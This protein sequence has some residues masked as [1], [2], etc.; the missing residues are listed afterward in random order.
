MERI[1]E[2]RKRFQVL[3]LVEALG[4]ARGE[5]AERVASHDEEAA[6]LKQKLESAKDAL[7]RLEVDQNAYVSALGK[8]TEEIDRL[9]RELVQVTRE[10]DEARSLLEQAYLAKGS[11][12]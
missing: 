6:G 11:S 12:P 10:R 3:A 2:S 4:A 9:E 7:A 1:G 5:L 8:R